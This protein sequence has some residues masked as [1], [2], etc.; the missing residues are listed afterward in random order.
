MVI[1]A[2]IGIL[3]G[4]ALGTRYKVLILVPAFAIGLATFLAIGLVRSMPL[5][6]TGVTTLLFVTGLQI[7]Y[8]T[9]GFC[10][11]LFSEAR[12]TRLQ[13]PTP[14]TAARRAPTA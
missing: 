6:S 10:R 1:A 11:I 12:Q 14:G 9:G 2:T 3:T 7:G 8:V 4:A 13:V 5:L